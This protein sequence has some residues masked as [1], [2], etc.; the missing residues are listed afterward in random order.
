M[1]PT[2]SSRV[3]ST[4]HAIVTAAMG[5]YTLWNFSPHIIGGDPALLWYGTT[6]YEL[7][8]LSIS[9]GY[10]LFD[11]SL[12]FRNPGLLDKKMLIHHCIALFGCITG[13]YTKVGLPFHCMFLINE[14][15]TPFVNNHAMY[16]KNKK[17]PYLVPNGLAMFLSY[18]FCRILL[19]A[20]LTYGMVRT[21]FTLVPSTSPFMFWS[22]TSLATIL[23]FLN[24]GWFY[25]IAKGLVKALAGKKVQD[26]IPKEYAKH[27]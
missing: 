6:S 17:W 8:L 14:A 13:T 20:Y 15:S 11:F 1:N 22:Q 10:F 5:L 24:I 4:I 2:S 12:G 7:I 3:V 19:N 26:G 25:R 23:Y 27:E 9:T 18:L 16:G 21:F